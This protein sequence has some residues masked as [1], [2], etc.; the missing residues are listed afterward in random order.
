MKAVV[1][2]LLLLG[3][4]LVAANA[5]RC[6][7]GHLNDGSKDL[8]LKQMK[9]HFETSVTQLFS[10]F[11]LQ[12][13]VLERPGLSKLVRARSD[14][15][16]K[17]GMDYAKKFFQREGNLNYT[18]FT[19]NFKFEGVTP[20]HVDGLYAEFY[21]SELDSLVTSSQNIANQL[22]S[23]YIS[24]ICNRVDPDMAKFVQ[25]KTTE[26]RETLRDMKILQNNLHSLFSNGMAVHIFD[27]TLL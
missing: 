11:K 4:A 16:W 2:A 27:N 13:R 15:N 22:H 18:E 5:R 1:T 24:D 20:R 26:E 9:T 21:R 25:D 12:S 14:E 6:S 23:S 19:T 8:L 17:E 7:A 10:S 3:P